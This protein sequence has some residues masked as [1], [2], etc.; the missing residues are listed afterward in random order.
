MDFEE[1]LLYIIFLVHRD[2]VVI[3][4]GEELAGELSCAVLEF[5]K[6]VLGLDLVHGLFM[7]MVSSVKKVVSGYR[8]DA[9]QLFFSCF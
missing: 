2:A 4:L 8:Y 3:V 1:F 5:T 6:L 9:A 7:V